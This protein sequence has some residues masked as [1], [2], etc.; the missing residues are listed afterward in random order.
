M[1]NYADFLG[2]VLLF[3][4]IRDMNCSCSPGP[5]RELW[6]DMELES[7]RDA[8][9]WTDEERYELILTAKL[10]DLIDDRKSWL[11]EEIRED[12]LS[13]AGDRFP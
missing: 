4:V 3:R 2:G 8:P 5:P 13:M 1:K 11:F 10:A 6:L 7:I 9:D 12:L